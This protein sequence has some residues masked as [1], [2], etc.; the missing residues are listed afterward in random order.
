[1]RQFF[2]L[3]FQPTAETIR[4]MVAVVAY[5]IILGAMLTFVAPRS[6]SLAGNIITLSYLVMF[7]VVLV[8]VRQRGDFAAVG[9]T[10]H[11]WLVATILGGLIGGLGLLGTI[12]AFPAGTFLIPAWPSLLALLAAGL[13]AG[14]IEDMVLYGYFQFR[15]E[16]AFGP[17][18]AVLGSA[19]AWTLAHGAVLS[20]PGAGAFA[21]QRVGVSSFLVSLFI[22][23]FVIGLIVHFTR[24]IW[25]GVVQNAVMGNVLTNL[26]M[27]SVMPDEVFIANPDILPVSLLVALLVLA[28]LAWMGYSLSRS[29]YCIEMKRV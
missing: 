13:S 6:G 9:I 17:P 12:N 19:L 21:A 22:A 27:F 20:M 7:A 3:R 28:G 14:L 8:F 4:A 11:R 2:T 25:A 5:I 15:L 24:N 23:F 26:Y 10:R 16:E 29:R 1:M 18:V